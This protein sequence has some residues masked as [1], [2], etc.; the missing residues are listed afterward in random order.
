MRLLRRISKKP[1]AN[2]V[3]WAKKLDSLLDYDFVTI[4]NFTS[5]NKTIVPMFTISNEGKQYLLYI[6]RR[7][8]ELRIANVLSIIAI[9][10]SLVALFR[11]T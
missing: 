11:T 10:I 5:D 3:E 7:Q 6:S 8:T 2:T 9:L 4:D 1:V